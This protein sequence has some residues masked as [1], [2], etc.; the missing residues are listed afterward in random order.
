M[1]QNSRWLLVAAETALRLGLLAVLIYL[2]SILLVLIG[3]DMD[4]EIVS[5]IVKVDVAIVALLAFFA[6]AIKLLKH[7]G[8]ELDEDNSDDFAAERTKE[9]FDVGYPSH[10]LDNLLGQLRQNRSIPARLVSP[11]LHLLGGDVHRLAQE[12]VDRVAKKYDDPPS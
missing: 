1:K 7:K 3:V 4:L 2:T 9:A 10:V 12:R 5:A 11:I 8:L 6:I